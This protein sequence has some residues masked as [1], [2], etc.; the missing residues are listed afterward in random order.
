MQQVAEV[1][2]SPHDVAVQLNLSVATIYRLLARGE[3]KAVKL[4]G[5]YRIRPQEVER[6]V[7]G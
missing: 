6:I 2:L 4:G 3:I 1:M 7:G 5:Q